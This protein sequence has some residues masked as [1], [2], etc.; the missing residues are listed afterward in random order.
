MSFS[1][2]CS[3]EAA[4]NSLLYSYKHGFSGFAARMS[5][6]QAQDIASMNMNMILDIIKLYFFNS[7]QQILKATNNVTEFPEVVSVIPNGIHKLHTTRSWD[8]IGVHHPSSKT[9][10]AESNLGEG[11][12]IGVIDTGIN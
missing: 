10:F 11:T 8:F 3:K 6:S 5:K 1:L 4:K 12:I 7:F 9:D 2:L